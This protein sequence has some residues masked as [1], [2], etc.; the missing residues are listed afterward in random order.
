M[1]EIQPA[2]SLA[3]AG[4]GCIQ[5]RQGGMGGAD[6]GTGDRMADRM[7]GNGR[8]QIRGAKERGGIGRARSTGEDYNILRCRRVV[9][10]YFKKNVKE[11]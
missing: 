1:G 8:E 9:R 3:G 4:S 10:K 11:T 6:R 7:V 2:K 5:G